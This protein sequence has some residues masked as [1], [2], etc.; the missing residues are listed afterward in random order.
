MTDTPKNLGQANPAATTVTDLYTVPAATSTVVSTISICNRSSTATTVRVSHAPVG[1]AD[2]VTHYFVYDAPLGGNET[3]WL[4]GGVS[5]ATTDKLR[6]YTAAN[7]VTFQA[8]GV[9][10]S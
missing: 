10:I 9:E 6:V 1:A 7:T 8:W 4:T 3:I 5:M 2:A